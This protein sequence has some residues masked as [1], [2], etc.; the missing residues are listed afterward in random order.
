MKLTWRRHQWLLALACPS[1]LKVT[2]W[3]HA[4][5]CLFYVQ[6][7]LQKVQN[8]M[9]FVFMLWSLFVIKFFTWKDECDEAGGDGHGSKDEGGD[10]GADLGQGGHCR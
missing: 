8:H 1:S 2:T 6:L 9:N 3:K 5:G 4:L 7:V 10:D